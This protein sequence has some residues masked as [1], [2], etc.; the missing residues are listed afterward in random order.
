MAVLYPDW[1]FLPLTATIRIPFAYTN[2]SGQ[3]IY[4]QTNLTGPNGGSLPVGWT[5]TVKQHGSITHGS[6][7]YGYHQATRTMPTFFAGEYTEDLELHFKR[8]LDSGYSSLQGEDVEPLNFKHYKSDDPAWILVDADD[9]EVD[10]E[11]WFYSNTSTNRWNEETPS[12]RV[13]GQGYGSTY[14]LEVR[15][16]YTPDNGSLRVLLAEGELSTGQAYSLE[17]TL[18]FDTKGLAISDVWHVFGGRYYGTGP[19]VGLC[20]ISDPIDNNQA[21]TKKFPKPTATDLRVS[22]VVRYSSTA[23]KWYV[24]KVRWVK[25]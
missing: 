9:F 13:S 10:N 21:S 23:T 6:T 17:T 25:K 18:V 8:F 20:L 19:N 4:L 15:T 11:S 16:A 1:F 7:L 24:D 2:Q 5:D 3:T 22:G 12:I 14:A